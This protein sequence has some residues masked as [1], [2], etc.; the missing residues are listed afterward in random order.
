MTPDALL[1]HALRSPEPARAL[2]A[3]VED[4]F[5]AGHSKE[6]LYALLEGLVLRLRRQ[7]LPREADED[8]VLDTMDALTGWCHP[9]A[10]LL[11]GD[12]PVR[13]SS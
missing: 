2:R 9:S 5:R 12:P 13:H 6:E 1:H 11:P 7:P 10:Q 8:L 4:L 3:A